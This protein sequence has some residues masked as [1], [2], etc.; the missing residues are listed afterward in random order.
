VSQRSGLAAQDLLVAA[1]SGYGWLLASVP[2]QMIQGGTPRPPGPRA[3][4]MAR[5]LGA[6]HLL[7]AMATAWAEAAG[8]PPVPVL[9]AG[10]AVDV[11]HAASMLGLAVINRPLRHAALADTVLEAAFGAFGIMAARRLGVTGEAGLATVQG[12]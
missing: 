7:Q 10:A 12:Q 3:A 5:V 1:R 4:T 11:T 9:L 8:L 6:R 2:R